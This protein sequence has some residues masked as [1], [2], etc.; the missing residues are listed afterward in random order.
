MSGLFDSRAA[1]QQI[2][3]LR[4]FLQDSK[5]ASAKA[6]A[7]SKSRS[8]IL[9][10]LS[11]LFLHSSNLLTD[12]DNTISDYQPIDPRLQ[13]S[14][15]RGKISARR[16]RDQKEF[17]KMADQWIR[18][19]AD[20]SAFYQ[21]HISAQTL[22]ERLLLFLCE[23]CY[24]A[25]LS[26]VVFSLMH[27]R[28][29]AFSGAPFS[30]GTALRFS[31]LT[32]A[33]ALL[34]GLQATVASL[35]QK[36]KL[37]TRRILQEFAYS[38]LLLADNSFLELADNNTI[39]MILYC[40]FEEHYNVRFWWL[41]LTPVLMLL[42]A[43]A[44]RAA[45]GPATEACFVAGVIVV[46]VAFAAA[47]ESG[48]SR[49]LQLLR[50]KAGEQKKAMYEF[51]SQFREMSLK[52]LGPRFKTILEGMS[53]DKIQTLNSLLNRKS[54]EE[55]PMA[56]LLLCSLFYGPLS[57]LAAPRQQAEAGSASAQYKSVELYFAVLFVHLATQSCVRR[58]RAVLA[59]RFEFARCKWVIEEFF[60]GYFCVLS[61]TSLKEESTVLQEGEILIEK[62]DVYQRD[63]QAVKDLLD[64]LLSASHHDLC[65]PV[66]GLHSRTFGDDSGSRNSLRSAP[67][68]QTSRKEKIVS[69]GAPKLEPA[70]RGCTLALKNVQL[71]FL[72]GARVC[73]FENNNKKL[74]RSF[75][76]MILGQ[77]F[78]EGGKF[79][80]RGS[81]SYFN[82]TRKHI[83]VGKTIRDNILFGSDFR[84]DRYDDILRVLS[85]QFGS[86][87]GQDFHQV[88]ENGRNLRKEDVKA[89]LFARFLYQ[90]CH[91][92]IIEDYL[93]ELDM[94]L[95]K[96]LIS[97]IIKH[98]LQKKTLFLCSN[99]QEI[100]KLTDHV[101]CL[102]SEA[103]YRVVPRDAFLE[104]IQG[105]PNNPQPISRSMSGLERLI[106]NKRIEVLR[107]KLKNS[108]FIE[109][110]GFEEELTIHKNLEATKKQIERMRQQN[111]RLLELLTFGIFLAHKK[112]QSG[113]YFKP[114][115]RAQGRDVV[116]H[117]RRFFWNSRTKRVIF[118]LVGLQACSGATALFI[119]GRV[120]ELT[121]RQGSEGADFRA[122]SVPLMLVLVSFTLG[123]IKFAVFRAA[124]FR[125]LE[126]S[127]R[128]INQAILDSRITEIVRRRPHTVLENI[129][130]DLNEIEAN[131][132][133]LLSGIVAGAVALT[134]NTAVI[135]YCDCFLSLVP[136]ACLCYSCLQVFKRLIPVQFKVFNYSILLQS[137]LDDLN[138][139]LLSLIGGY[140]IAGRIQILLNSVNKLCDNSCLVRT[141]RDRNVKLAL[142][143]FAV[144]LSSLYLAV[145]FTLTLLGLWNV[146]NWMQVKPVFFIWASLCC[147]RGAFLMTD[148]A[149]KISVASELVFK[150]VRIALFVED[151]TASDPGVPSQTPVPRQLDFS[152][153]LLLKDVTVTTSF[154]PIIKR[155]SFRVLSKSRVGLFGIDGG[156]RSKIYD[157]IC[158]LLQRDPN[159]R[160]KLKVF[161]QDIE[162]LSETE[163][164]QVVFLM[165]RSPVL[166]TGTVLQNLDPY[167]QHSEETIFC[168]LREVGIGG[169]LERL[170]QS[171]SVQ[172]TSPVEPGRTVEFRDTFE[173]K[174]SLLNHLNSMHCSAGGFIKGLSS[175]KSDTLLNVRTDDQKNHRPQGS[176][177]AISHKKE[178]EKPGIAP[179][180]LDLFFQRQARDPSPD[181]TSPKDPPPH[182]Q[183]STAN[184]AEQP[185]A[186]DSRN[187][188]H[189]PEQFIS[190][191]NPNYPL[192]NSAKTPNESPAP[193]EGPKVPQTDPKPGHGRGLKEFQ[194][195]LL[196]P[197]NLTE[198]KSLGES[199]KKTWQEEDPLSKKREPKTAGSALSDPKI[200]IKVL[201][202]AG[203]V[204]PGEA[205]KTGEIRLGSF[206]KVPISL[207]P[208]HLD[209]EELVQDLQKKDFAAQNF[210]E[211]S[212]C[213]FLNTKT[214]MGGSSVSLEAR[215]AVIFCRAVLDQPRLLLAFEESLS[216]G[217]GVEWNLKFL[218]QSLPETT[219]LVITKDSRNLFFYDSIVF[220]DA[221]RVLD[222]GNPLNLVRNTE[223]Y[224]SRYLKETDTHG[225]LFLR[226]R[227]KLFDEKPNFPGKRN[228][229]AGDSNALGQTVKW[230]DLSDGVSS[231]KQPSSKT[232]V[233]VDREPSLPLSDLFCSDVVLPPRELLQRRDEKKLRQQS[234]MSKASLE[235]SEAPVEEEKAKTGICRSVPQ[236][237][238]KSLLS[239][240]KASKKSSKILVDEV[241][242][243]KP[244]KNPQR[245]FSSATSL[246]EYQIPHEHSDRSKPIAPAEFFKKLKTPNF[247]KRA[248][249]K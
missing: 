112:K 82:P 106:S 13:G 223:S 219:I 4:L 83:L 108:L 53:F 130:S 247:E 173:E 170:H 50:H 222:K 58:F 29:S 168:L 176:L 113:Q 149:E 69:R 165:E 166:F 75:I 225:L 156:G 91:I 97:N 201:S 37:I 178:T 191:K 229:N 124:A 79:L 169:V 190:Q 15:I 66:A 138:F 241:A 148:L 230:K 143:F 72:P 117:F 244:L 46:R 54:L 68:P 133:C 103:E 84:Q 43:V 227:L 30:L 47:M 136:I 116:R 157:L 23:L 152:A 89:M 145:G 48:E 44:F 167:R 102:E 200:N 34:H 110:V 22:R 215:K 185:T 161:G 77:S 151:Q 150:M 61:D 55:L 159:E 118:L 40:R 3:S 101:V 56:C 195:Q 199:T 96:E 216:F 98:T 192:S 18:L 235:D 236:F 177:E 213:R 239:I 134:L 131:L 25:L 208:N 64:R 180:H 125:L 232:R 203:E 35:E 80:V 238:S 224:L 42:A 31:G 9:D 204:L 129:G 234:D 196:T 187:K 8:S 128:A 51:L 205:R 171:S 92:Y 188:A 28:L 17:S 100:I 19:L 123:I 81:I 158:G 153:G 183:G 12:K 189:R 175:Y 122:V 228:R 242:E 135:F 163:V 160:S 197:S 11:L 5:R 14:E 193:A 109:N 6:A 248:L 90:D 99:H 93:T 59:M 206:L 233:A 115:P 105:P 39:H 217:Q 140:R 139:Q 127:N 162:K 155:I 126:F 231:N 36:I 107:N 60:N 209:T 87:H 181:N 226:E 121:D 164:K 2:E 210:C 114:L 137:K 104:T 67:T 38:R 174:Q 221:G 154:Q 62:C 120:L 45:A 33:H 245:D 24:G 194:P 146:T 88:A 207:Q 141:Y 182:Q 240:D 86:Y 214:G 65:E 246:F 186:L 243:E 184:P 218:S 32:L 49:A 202:S 73:I 16:P 198:A 142:H 85:L 70:N 41:P 94:G 132:P 1:H 71:H 10:S 95:M 7:S 144:L 20:E 212:I 21:K 249:L 74:V 26:A 78:L 172:S 63:K 211:E 76:D 147:F 119:E 111:S 52:K 237:E 220:M 27:F 57:Q 179:D